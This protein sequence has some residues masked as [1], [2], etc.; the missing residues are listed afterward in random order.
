M[1]ILL[2]EDRCADSE[3]NVK[4]MMQM[5]DE[6]EILQNA[7]RDIAYALIQDAEAKSMDLTQLTHIHLSASTPIPQK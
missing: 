5:Q 7:L 4:Q 3:Q 1:N 2:Q 6:F